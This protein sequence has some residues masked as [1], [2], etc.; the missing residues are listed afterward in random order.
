MLFSLAIFIA[1]IRFNIKLQ[2][3][4]TAMPASPTSAIFFIVCGPIVG[5]SA[6]ISCPGLIVFTRTPALA[7]MRFSSRICLM[8]KI[9]LSVPSAPSTET[10]S[11]ICMAGPRRRR[12]P[13]PHPPDAGDVAVRAAEHARGKRR[14]GA[15]GRECKDCRRVA[16][17]GHG[18]AAAWWSDR[19]GRRR[20]GS[21]D[22]VIGV[23]NGLIYGI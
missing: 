10:D 21:S 16:W 1:S 22:G 2:P 23:G 17:E 4:S 7:G 6:L 11:D 9:I 5:R 3:A 13:A 18:D 20:N 14:P 8:R 12:T 15:D 19:W